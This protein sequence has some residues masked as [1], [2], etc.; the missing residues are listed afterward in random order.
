M[1]YI[2]FYPLLCAE[3]IIYL[4]LAMEWK[5]SIIDFDSAPTASIHILIE[6]A[7]ILFAYARILSRSATSNSPA[8]CG[9][10]NRNSA[11]KFYRPEIVLYRERRLRLELLSSNM[12]VAVLLT[13]LPTPFSV[14]ASLG[15]NCKANDFRPVY[16]SRKQCPINYIW[17]TPSEQRKISGSPCPEDSKRGRQ[18]V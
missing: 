7:S 3:V 5:I 14:W 10:Y 11:P 17:I 15:R 8:T 13:E 9:S 6:F 18:I 4:A 2:Y 1:S 16:V 12:L